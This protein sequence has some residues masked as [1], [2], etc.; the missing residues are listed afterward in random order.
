ME[1]TKE[2]TNIAKGLAILLMLS[3]HLYSFHDRLLNG[4]YYIP[5]IPSFDTELYIGNFG[6]VCISMFLFLSGYGMFLGYSHSNK[7]SLQYSL[8]KLKDFYLTYWIYFLIF[9]P[10]GLIFFKDETLWNSNE[11]R[12]SIDLRIF[13]EG[14]FGWSPRYNCLLYTS[15]SPRD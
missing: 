10:I 12:Y 2:R 6:N 14:F 8:G 9:V 3:H 5:L 4:N 11:I 1:F 13:L 15:P 7:S